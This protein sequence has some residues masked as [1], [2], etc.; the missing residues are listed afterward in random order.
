MKDWMKRPFLTPA[1]IK[2][3]DE[4]PDIITVYPELFARYF[5][6]Q[7]MYS[8][9][10][11]YWIYYHSD[12]LSYNNVDDLLQNFKRCESCDSWFDADELIDTESMVG[13]G[14]GYV[15]EDCAGTLG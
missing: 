10:H 11:S 6:E 3:N 12:A 2:S 15:C 14:V 5:D 1:D 7:D 4:T 13:G 9:F 8:A